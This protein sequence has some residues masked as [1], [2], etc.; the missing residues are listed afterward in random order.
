[1]RKP[2]VFSPPDQPILIPKITTG[3]FFVSRALF[4]H[5]RLAPVS[6]V[7]TK[8]R[9][10]MHGIIYLVGLV[11]VVLAVLSLLGLG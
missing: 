6:G 1:M 5:E 4:F 8:R 9:I 11:V 10:N 7:A 3:N 2:S